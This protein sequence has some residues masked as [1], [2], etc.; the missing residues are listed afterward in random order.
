VPGYCISC[1]FLSAFAG[2]HSGGGHGTQYTYTH[3]NAD[4]QQAFVCLEV[5]RL[6]GWLIDVGADHAAD[7][8][9]HVVEAV[10]LLAKFLEINTM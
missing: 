9:P 1:K 3:P 10:E 7:L 8:H 5:S 2:R 4:D 6:V